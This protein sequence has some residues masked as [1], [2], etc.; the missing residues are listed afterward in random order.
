M[1]HNC[2]FCSIVNIISELFFKTEVINSLDISRESSFD[3]HESQYYSSVTATTKKYMKMQ[4]CN[5]E[6]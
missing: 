4:S 1:K 3:L 5:Q 2:V 6:R